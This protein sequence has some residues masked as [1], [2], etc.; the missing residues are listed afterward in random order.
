MK[1]PL[2]QVDSFTGT[3]FKGNP[4]AICFLD[5]WLDDEILL[6]MANENNLSETGFIVK[7]KSMYE[8][9]WFTPVCEVDLCGHATLAAA[10]ILFNEYNIASDEILFH[11]IR[12]GK[13]I[14]KKES[15]FIT[16][17]FPIAKYNKIP[18]E[19]NIYEALG[20]KP[21]EVYEAK[22]LY[23]LVYDKEQD[24]I[25]IRPDFNKLI[26]LDK[27]AVLITA[28]SDTVDFATRFFAPK[29]GVNEDPVT[30]SAYTIAAPYW[31]HTLNKKT[32]HAVQLSKRT[33]HVTCRLSGSNVL[34]SGNAK[35]YLRGEIIL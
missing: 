22:W 24:I 18:L 10:Y 34:I 30:G 27:E 6:D 31:I 17:S 2:Y 16:L 13:F 26:K 28:K 15:S 19:D 32:V 35:L 29:L 11:S 3:L 20:K 21:N 14:V 9:R 12:S 23:M 8:I 33:G 7:N 25:D 4:A 5:R 1:Y